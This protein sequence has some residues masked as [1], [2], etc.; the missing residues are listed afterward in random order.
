MNKELRPAPMGGYPHENVQSQI[1]FPNRI[2]TD[3]IDGKVLMEVNP[4]FYPQIVSDSFIGEH[5]KRFLMDRIHDYNNALGI[6]ENQIRDMRQE[7]P[8]MPEDFRFEQVKN[9]KGELISAYK[10]EGWIMVRN[11]N[12]EL[13]PYNFKWKVQNWKEKKSEPI[14]L[15][16]PNEQIAFVTL[17]AL[18]IISDADFEK[19]IEIPVKIISDVP[20]EPSEAT[21]AYNAEMEKRKAFNR[22]YACAESLWD[23]ENKR[24]VIPHGIEGFENMIGTPVDGEQFYYDRETKELFKEA[25]V[26]NGSI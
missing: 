15:S 24:F 23:E 4:E 13:L 17:R 7:S 20:A 1:V 8:F 14:E 3:I 10:K 12:K 22:K 2:K 6:A 25:E 21:K 26:N 18:G 5:W 11:N 9:E 16:L 19:D